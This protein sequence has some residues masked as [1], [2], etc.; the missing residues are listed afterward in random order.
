MYIKKYDKYYRRIYKHEKFPF[1]KLK[2]DATANKI[3]YT[4]EEKTLLVIAEN[5]TEISHLVNYLNDSKLYLY[6]NPSPFIKTKIPNARYLNYHM[7]SYFNN[8]YILKERMTS[9]LQRMKRSSNNIETKRITDSFS[10]VIDTYFEKYG[11]IRNEHTHRIRYIDSDISRLETFECY[12]RSC[13]FNKTTLIKK[14]HVSM[15]YSE[16]KK[17]WLKFM[18]T[19]NISLIDL[20][21]QYFNF[22]I[23]L[24]LDKNES[25]RILLRKYSYE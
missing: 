23:E 5:L 7:H 6:S 9:F 18:K 25:F 16:V 4:D 3:Q 11:K 2:G 24:I 19:S 15:A 8:V 22:I 20:V 13:F 21:S 10:A 17:S 14:S 1:T 12:Y